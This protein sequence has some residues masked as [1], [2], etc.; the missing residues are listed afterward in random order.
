MRCPAEAFEP[1]CRERTIQ[2][3]A[4]V[5]YI[6]LL[7]VA[8]CL[9]RQLLLTTAVCSWAT[10]AAYVKI[11][12]APTGGGYQ[13]WP[14]LARLQDGRLMCVFYN[15]A[16]NDA[17]QGTPNSPQF[18]NAGRIDYSISSNSG[19]SWTA[20]QTLYDGPAD[21]H[22]ASITQLKD[23]RLIVNFFKDYY[24]GYTGRYTGLSGTMV[25]TSDD[26]GKHWSTPREV[27]PSP[28]VTSSPI[29]EIS[30]PA[31]SRLIL[32]LY[33]YTG[34][35][36]DTYGAAGISDDRGATWS[37]PVTIPLPLPG[38]N[39]PTYLPAETSVLQLKEDGSLFAAERSPGDQRMCFSTSTNFGDTWSVSEPFDFSGQCPYLHRAPNGV[40]LLAY[41]NDPAR[42]TSLRY[43]S[44]RC[45]TWS[46]EVVVDSVIGAYPSI[47]DLE[48]GSQLIAYY[49]D[50]GYHEGGGFG[51]DIR[52]RRCR[53]TEAGEFEWLAVTPMP[54]PG[55][56]SLLLIAAAGLLAWRQRAWYR[57]FSSVG[58]HYGY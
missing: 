37:R 24:E 39:V 44:D 22:D 26:L 52:I 53:V 17:V 40:V 33:H 41:R 2:E 19:Y 46:D 11:P 48:D 6:C 13:A 7:R 4:I 21:D 27:C 49:E 14:D 58:E 31:G 30:T 56:I 54:E 51:S 15:G 50:F 1:H 45:Q 34:G 18:P 38:S 36:S 32:P 42:R 47:V 55:T 35:G 57:G 10:A 29:C 23:G 16:D 3:E 9:A 20:P 12:Q 28:Y 5:R 43:S 8:G 25:M